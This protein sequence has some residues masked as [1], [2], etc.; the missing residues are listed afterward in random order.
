MNLLRKIA[1]CADINFQTVRDNALALI[2]SE[3]TFFE[4]V[5][6]SSDSEKLC[7]NRLEGRVID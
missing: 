4:S 1:E 5:Q 3:I 7:A 6:K 2:E